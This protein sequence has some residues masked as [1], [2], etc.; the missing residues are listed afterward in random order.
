MPGRR[1]VRVQYEGGY[2][3]A[4]PTDLREAALKLATITYAHRDD[5]SR[6]SVSSPG[7]G[8]LSVIDP[9]K[10]PDDV[11]KTIEAYRRMGRQ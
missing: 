8:G 7:G 3:G 4:V 10:W 1:T 2:Q 9:G 11:R 6:Q 5:P